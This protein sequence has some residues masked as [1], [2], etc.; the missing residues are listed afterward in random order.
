MNTEGRAGQ[1]M[2]MCKKAKRPGDEDMKETTLRY[3]SYLSSF[4]IPP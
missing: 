3:E 4:L 1:E 2:E